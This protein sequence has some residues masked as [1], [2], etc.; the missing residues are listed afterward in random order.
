[1]ALKLAWAVCQRVAG[2]TRVTPAFREFLLDGVVLASLGLIA[3]VVP[4]HDEN[5]ALV[6][7]GLKRLREDTVTG[8]SR[9]YWR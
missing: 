7:H 9:R 2:G 6:V 3:D 4:L 5:R 1:M 8:S